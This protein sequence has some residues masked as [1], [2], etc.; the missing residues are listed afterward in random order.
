MGFINMCTVFLT[1][2][3]ADVGSDIGLED[4]E[5]V[6]SS[7]ASGSEKTNFLIQYLLNQRE[8]L[9]NFAKTVLFAVIIFLIGRRIVSIALKMTDKWMVRRDVET[10]VQK[11]VMSLARLVFNLLLIFVIAGILG[12]GTS[13]IVAMV[14][15]A[16]LAVGLALQG[17]LSNFAGGVLILLLKPFQVG[18][19]IIAVGEEGT[20]ESIDIFY[21]KLITSDNKVIVIPN[22]TISNSN[23]TNTSKEQYRLLIVDFMAPYSLETSKVRSAVIEIMEKYEKISN[24]KAMSVVISKLDPV[25]VKMQAKAWVKTEDYW[26][27]RFYMLEEIKNTS[28]TWS[29]LSQ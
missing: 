2:I 18:D 1:Q 17:S 28:D 9:L 24:D 12:V 10:G 20:V 26:E 21:T 13:S 25:Y 7:E 4:V 23:V 8:P 27:A 19:Y 22:G 14:G 11:F 3:P 15:S 16:G 5:K 6:M 29:N